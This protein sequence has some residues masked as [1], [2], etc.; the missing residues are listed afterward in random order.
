MPFASSLFAPILSA[1]SLGH[2]SPAPV[3]PG[4]LAQ[5]RVLSP[6]VESLTVVSSAFGPGAPIP[7]NFTRDGKSLSPPLSWFGAPARTR[8]YA[9]IVED[10]DAAAGPYPYLHWVAFDIPAEVTA[11]PT[12]LRNQPRTDHPKIRQGP[13]D[14]DGMGW[15]GPHPPVGDKPHRYHF[16][17]FALSRP[18]GLAPGASREAV[19]AAMNDRVLAE[20]ELVGTYQSPAGTLAKASGPQQT[21]SAAH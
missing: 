8:A 13:N 18:L 7:A 14:S 9:V 16:Q 19:I 5:D 1:L 2:A 17:V 3:E 21:A 11:L 12:G 6:A 15:A 4:A 10:E 20:G